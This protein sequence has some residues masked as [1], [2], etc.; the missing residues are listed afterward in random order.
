MTCVVPGQICS[1]SAVLEIRGCE[2]CLLVLPYC[3]FHRCAT[4]RFSS[5]KCLLK[6]H[7]FASHSKRLLCAGVKMLRLLHCLAASL[8]FRGCIDHAFEEVCKRMLMFVHY[9]DV[10]YLSHRWS[11]LE[12]TGCYHLRC[13]V[14]LKTARSNAVQ[15][16][17]RGEVHM[18]IFSQ[19]QA[20]GDISLAT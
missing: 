17:A 16:G 6:R 11:F 8:V 18:C 4:K 9:R 7:N 10:R 20:K 19:W 15:I 12:K 5:F 2:D 13:H 14:A 1:Q 3:T